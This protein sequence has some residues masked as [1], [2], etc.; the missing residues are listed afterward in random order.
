MNR[1][2][3]SVVKKELEETR[4]GVPDLRDGGSGEGMAGPGRGDERSDGHGCWHLSFPSGGGSLHKQRGEE[5]DKESH[6]PRGLEWVFQQLPI[7][8]QGT[9]VKK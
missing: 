4:G 3:A 2:S 7:T 8:E 6:G 5:S 1:C 9:Q